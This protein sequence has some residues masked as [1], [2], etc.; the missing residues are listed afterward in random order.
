MFINSRLFRCYS[1]GFQRKWIPWN[2]SFFHVNRSHSIGS[3]SITDSICHTYFTVLPQLKLKS[4]LF[5]FVRNYFLPLKQPSSS[6]TFYMHAMPFSKENFTMIKSNCTILPLL[7]GIW[8]FSAGYTFCVENVNP[9]CT[10]G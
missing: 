3:W 7:S 2:P 1:K 10:D 6:L 4:L 5:F 8:L 9:S